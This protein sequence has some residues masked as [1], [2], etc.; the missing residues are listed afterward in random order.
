MSPEKM[1]VDPIATPFLMG[2]M[3]KVKDHVAVKA[4]TVTATIAFAIGIFYTQTNA[5][6]VK[7]DEY[8]AKVDK[9]TEIVMLLQRSQDLSNN[10]IGHIRTDMDKLTAQMGQMQTNIAKIRRR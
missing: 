3:V 4:F 2:M 6:M 5:M 10:N 9:L 1:I 7:Q 8:T